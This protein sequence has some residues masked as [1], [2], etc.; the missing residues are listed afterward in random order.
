MDS[1]EEEQTTKSSPRWKATEP[2][3]FFQ[4]WRASNAAALERMRK[5]STRMTVA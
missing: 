2:G 5:M 4:R 1:I 3:S